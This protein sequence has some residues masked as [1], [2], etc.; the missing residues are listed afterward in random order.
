M[1][2]GREA[3]WAMRPRRLDR[4]E[5]ARCN[6]L[7]RADACYI[8]KY[9]SPLRACYFCPWFFFALVAEC[10]RAPV[11]QDYSARFAVTRTQ[12]TH[13]STTKSYFHFGNQV[14][15]QT[16]LFYFFKPVV[17]MH[18]DALSL[19]NQDTNTI[20]SWRR[21][22]IFLWPFSLAQSN[23]VL[24]SCNNISSSIAHRARKHTIK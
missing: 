24:P 21:S 16:K 1:C 9:K 18:L 14:H 3:Q 2:L 22:T 19:D 7:E 23:A 6:L 12:L 4:R 8:C 10:A 20:H 15:K 11:I 5:D 17:Q 13:T